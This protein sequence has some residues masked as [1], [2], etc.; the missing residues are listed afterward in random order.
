[1]ND[2]K[3][4][5]IAKVPKEKVL[6]AYQMYGSYRAAAKAV[7]LT[8][9]AVRT[10]ILK[11]YP[12]AKPNESALAYRKKDPR[13]H[14]AFPLWLS[15]HGGKP[16]PRSIMK[17]AELSGCSRNSITCYFYRRR[18]AVADKLR[19]LPDIRLIGTTL[20]VNEDLTSAFS[21]NGIDS[22]EYLIDKYSLRVKIS[23]LLKDKQRVIVPIND[24]KNYSEAILEAASKSP[25]YL[26]DQQLELSSKRGKPSKCHLAQD[27]HRPSSD[28]DTEENQEPFQ[29]SCP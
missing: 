1:M 23:V 26:Q 19:A 12:D 22:Y 15:M 27:T 7:G 4:K 9:P 13:H 21:T 2:E 29:D 16:L 6:K 11:Y 8:H 28:T 17:L 14:G 24:I 5:R 25:A 3:K 20:A 18:K 10:V